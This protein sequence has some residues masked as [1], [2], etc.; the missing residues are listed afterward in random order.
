MK[1]QEAGLE[2]GMAEGGSR[3][4]NG[5]GNGNGRGK[6]RQVGLAVPGYLSHASS[7]PAVGKKGTSLPPP[8]NRTGERRKV[9]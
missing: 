7:S 9:L 6:R 8:K 2:G 4:R 5:N 1:L 3:E